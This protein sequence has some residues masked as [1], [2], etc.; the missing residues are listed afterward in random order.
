VA[1]ALGA[2]NWRAYEEGDEMRIY[3]LV[4]SVWGEREEVPEWNRWLAGWRWMFSH[5][6]AGVGEIWLA[7][8]KG[9]LV[10]QYPLVSADMLIS[11]EIRKVAQL[12]DTM[13]S[14]NF[15]RLGIASELGARAL[16][17]LRQRNLGLAFGFP[18]LEAFPVH[19]RAGWIDVCTCQSVI[20][21]LNYRRLT[22]GFITGYGAGAL[23]LSAA[24]ATVDRTINLKKKTVSSTTI[25]IEKVT[26]FDSRFDCLWRDISD[27]YEI[28]LVRNST[29]LNWRYIENPN[30]EYEI[31]TAISG[32]SLCGYAVLECDRQRN[33][34]IWRIV[35]I[36]AAADQTEVVGELVDL[37]VSIAREAG[38][39]AVVSRVVGGRYLGLYTA[40]GFYRIP[41]KNGRFIAFS[42]SDEVSEEYLAAA[43]RWFI[44]LGDLPMV[45]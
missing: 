30:I 6:P 31:Y 45:Y 28:I 20:K 24:L 44:Q 10:G 17:Q 16:A 18:T 23:P 25:R 37:V 9:E 26:R 29:Y 40:C 3:E 12:A 2:Y 8:H 19:R 15:R 41:G 22:E 33:C 14:P 42:S 11:G 34:S 36:I 21:P 5:N 27:D 7:E 4:R 38:A 1:K 32:E 35:D 13:T 39:D 43:E